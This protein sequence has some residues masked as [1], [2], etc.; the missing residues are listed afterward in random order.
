MDKMMA[1]YYDKVGEY[2]RDMAIEG[3]Y[4]MPSFRPDLVIENADG[5]P[6]AVVEV[7]SR[8]NLSTDVATEMRRNI[9]ERGLPVHI[10][11]FLLLSQDIGYLWKESKRNGSEETPAYVFPM[12]KVIA[13]YSKRASDRRLYETELSLLVLQWLTHLSTE[14]LEASEEPEKTLALS[15]FSDSIKHAMVLIEEEL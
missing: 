9:L 1:L 7:K 13:R 8:L 10:P 4:T 3:L 6:I 14:A 11:Y 15:G 5:H 2:V 12:D